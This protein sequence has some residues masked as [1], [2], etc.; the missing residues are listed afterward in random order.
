MFQLA[1]VLAV[2]GQT[3][4]AARLAGFADHYADQHQLSQYATAIAIRR[5]L[6]ERLHSAITPDD[7]QAAMAAGAAWSEQEAITAAQTV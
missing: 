7:C 6:A 1:L 4:R 2:Q 3:D 5:R